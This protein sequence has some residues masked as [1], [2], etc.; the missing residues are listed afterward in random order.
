MIFILFCIFCC[1]TFGK[2]EKKIFGTKENLKK[3][4]ASVRDVFMSVRDA[5]FNGHKSV[6]FHSRV[7]IFLVEKLHPF[8]YLF[9]ISPFRLAC[10]LSE[11]FGID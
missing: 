10:V 7:F 4:E 3:S 9:Y 2:F 6:S 1:H 5:P 11:S 8:L